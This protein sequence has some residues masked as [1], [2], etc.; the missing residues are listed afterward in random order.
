[1]IK[2]FT[3]KKF[4]HYWR[5]IDYIFSG[6][7]KRQYFRDLSDERSYGKQNVNNIFWMDKI[8]TINA[9]SVGMGDGTPKANFVIVDVIGN[10]LLV[11]GDYSS[12][13]NFKI[14]PNKF[15]NKNKLKLLDKYSKENYFFINKIKF[16]FSILIVIILF[17]AFIIYKRIKKRMIKI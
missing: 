1:M 8:G 11:K 13:D 10:E 3:S 7:S 6:N 12:I 2:V 4:T 16:Y 15:I 14:L 5:K 17:L 9:Y